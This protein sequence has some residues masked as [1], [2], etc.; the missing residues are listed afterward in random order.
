MT[1]R[2]SFANGCREE[3]YPPICLHFEAEIADFG[4]NCS[5]LKEN[6]K[7]NITGRNVFL[8]VFTNSARKLRKTAP[9]RSPISA[10]SFSP[11][12]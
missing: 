10:Y 8:L 7:N 2:Y 11:P 12:W 5:I 3:N 9:G 6:P 4:L 1:K